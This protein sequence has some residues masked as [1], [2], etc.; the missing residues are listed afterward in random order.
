MTGPELTACSR[1][2][3]WHADAIRAA[4]LDYLAAERGGLRALASLLERIADTLPQPSRPSALLVAAAR[5]RR[6]A[7][8]LLPLED[9]SLVAP[10]E[11]AMPEKAGR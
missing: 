3:R 9:R 1:R 7:L 5:L 4:P 10:I 11:A 6:C 2:D 8:R